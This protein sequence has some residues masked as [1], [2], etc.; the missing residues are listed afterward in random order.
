MRPTI[1]KRFNKFQPPEIQTFRY[2][3]WGALG[4]LLY[5]NSIDANEVPLQQVLDASPSDTEEESCKFCDELVAAA[6]I[7]VVGGAS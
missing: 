5:L 2:L 7:E 4:V 1:V 6:L 3:S